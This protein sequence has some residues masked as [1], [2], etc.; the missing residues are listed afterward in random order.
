MFNRIIERSDNLV[1]IFAPAKIN[2]FLAISGK[3]EDGYHEITTLL[4]KLSFGDTLEIRRDSARKGAS[5]E[6]PN[7]PELENEK[8]L[9]FQAIKN[10]C[11]Q[12]G[13]DWAI[14]IRLNKEIPMM[15]GLGGG[16]SDAVA[17]LI[18]LNELA[19]K[20]LSLK[21]LVDLASGI[22][23]D[24]PGFLADGLCLAKGRGEMVSAFDFPVAK[25]LIGQNVLLFRPNLGLSTYKVYQRF[26]A[27]KRYS[28]SNWINERLKNWGNR[29][30]RTREF[31]H[32]D[33][34]SAVFS[35][36]FYFPALFKH[37]VSKFS[38]TPR[39]SGSGSSCYVIIP[40][41]FDRFLDLKNEILRAWG[42]D[43]WVKLTKII[44]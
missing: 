15:S 18:G 34:E 10:W 7:F 35:K 14:D 38:L 16:S 2:L 6:C 5:L 13:E 19:D 23:S 22:G 20:K 1:K 43:S 41:D 42:D 37:I 3:R 8:N 40:E 12:T 21:Q 9:V 17:T 26:S 28:S 36:H 39:M 30:L 33:L 25:N 27:N 24:C 31:L 11:R 29:K 4:G 44:N 32:N